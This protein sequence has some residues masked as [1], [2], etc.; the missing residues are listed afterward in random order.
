MSTKTS[1]AAP[2]DALYVGSAP[3]HDI[4]SIVDPHTLCAASDRGERISSRPPVTRGIDSALLGI[5]VGLV[6]VAASLTMVGPA[7]LAIVIAPVTVSV[8]PS[9]VRLASPLSVPLPVA[10]VTLLLVSFA[11]NAVPPIVTAF[12]SNVPSVVNAPLNCPTPAVRNRCPSA[13]VATAK[14]AACGADK[15]GER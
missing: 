4:A 14:R 5:S 9:N 3:C 7:A 12:A 8:D 1:L 2:N 11:N 6:A 10:V 15:A 13:A